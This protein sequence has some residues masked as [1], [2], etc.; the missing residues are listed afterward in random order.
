MEHTSIDI[1]ATQHMGIVEWFTQV[2]TLGV[3][4]L[5]NLVTM[6]SDLMMYAQ[7]NNSAEAG[8]KSIS[9]RFPM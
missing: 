1:T 4:S 5:G 8:L 3:L 9:I 7:W 6:R 2:P